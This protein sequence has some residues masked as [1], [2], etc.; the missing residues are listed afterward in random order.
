[1]LEFE[2]SYLLFESLLLYKFTSL[3]CHLMKFYIRAE[4]LD[5]KLFV[6]TFPKASHANTNAKI[7]CW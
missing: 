5:T 4:F 7:Y 1:M 2:A 6:F 3:P